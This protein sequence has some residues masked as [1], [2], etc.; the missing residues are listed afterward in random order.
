[1]AFLSPWPDR[2]L[3]IAETAESLLARLDFDCEVRAWRVSGPPGASLLLGISSPELVSA[4]ALEALRF[5]L[6]PRLNARLGLS[7]RAAHLRLVNLDLADVPADT[8]ALSSELVRRLLGRTGT[9]FEPSVP[10]PLA[11]LP[12]PASPEPQHY[13]SDPFTGGFEV[14]EL[15]DEELRQGFD[16][17]GPA[18]QSSSYPP[19][20][21][22]P[23]DGAQ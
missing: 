23:L 17:T 11:T 21:R 5:Y 6:V 12:M 4:E 18:S 22:P 10:A 15:S 7:L 9:G 3:K 14:R 8:E 16:A 20:S 2:L 19:D 1:M 13:F